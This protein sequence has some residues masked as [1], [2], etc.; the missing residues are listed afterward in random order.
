MLLSFLQLN[1]IF[2]K[3]LT[4]HLPKSVLRGHQ[5]HQEIQEKGANKDYEESK[6]ERTRVLFVRQDPKV[7]RGLKVCPVKRDFLE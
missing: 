5:G 4:V 6:V 1:H 2:A 3:R 7:L